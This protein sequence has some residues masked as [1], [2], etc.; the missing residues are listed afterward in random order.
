MGIEVLYSQA[1]PSRVNGFHEEQL[2]SYG[3]GDDTRIVGRY[4]KVKG[5]RGSRELQAKGMPARGNANLRR[6]SAAKLE[7]LYAGCRCFAKIED[8]TS[9]GE[10][11]T[12]Q[13]EQQQNHATGLSTTRHAGVRRYGPPRIKDIELRFGR[14]HDTF[15]SRC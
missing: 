13:S 14:F 6:R 4:G 15:G 1:T 3:G 9:R 2:A 7:L 8:Q 10:D 12:T 5:R 11:N